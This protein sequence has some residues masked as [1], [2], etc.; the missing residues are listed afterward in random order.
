MNEEQ[1]ILR[2]MI[3]DSDGWAEDEIRRAQADLAEIRVR[4]VGSDR[5]AGSEAIQRA[6]GHLVSAL[7]ALRQHEALANTLAY[8]R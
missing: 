3:A 2:D 6:M 1:E 7:A 5:R 4:Q 8:R